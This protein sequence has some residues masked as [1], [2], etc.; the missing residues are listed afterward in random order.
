M[1][2]EGDLQGSEILM[3][4][5][6]DLVCPSGDGVMRDVHTIELFHDLNDLCCG[7][8]VD[9]GKVGDQGQGVFGEVHF[10]PGE[11]NG[12]PANIDGLDRV[13]GD[14]EDFP[15]QRDI[16]LVGA[17]AFSLGVVSV[18]SKPVAIGKVF[19][20]GHGGAAFRAGMGGILFGRSASA[21]DKLMSAFGIF[22]SETLVAM[23]GVFSELVGLAL[24]PWTKNS[25]MVSHKNSF[26]YGS[27]R[28]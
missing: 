11:R 16:D 10:V 24:A 1:R 20:D 13:G 26:R 15:G 2:A 14:M 3:E 21:R 12:Q 27:N 18:A 9:Q 7:N 22:A 25:V 23:K 28:V 17:L 4:V 8:G 5:Q 6:G 19:E